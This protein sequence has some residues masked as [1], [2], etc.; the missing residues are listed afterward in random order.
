MLKEKL[1]KINIILA[2]GSPR[3]QQFFKEMDLH[4]TIRLKEIE[5]IYP[6]HLQ[7]EEITNFLAELKASAFENELKENDV[8]VTSDTIVWLNG[9]ALGKPKDYDDAFKM[10]QQLANQTHEVITS[11]CLKSIDK[12]DVFH[13]V[14]KVTFANLSDEAITYYLNN[15]K[16]FDKAGS[17]GIQDWIG[18]IGIS[19]IEGSYTNVV[20]LPTEML[21]Q[22]LMN[23]V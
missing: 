18:L 21:F 10:L 23:Y 9:K 11:V 13:C 1:N 16:P 4:Y 12:T 19:K 20:G 22:K 3:R 5:E 14:T 8:L 15:Y 6:E 2:S 17:Y 7:A